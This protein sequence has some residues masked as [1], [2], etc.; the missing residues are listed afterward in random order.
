[1]GTALGQ[2]DLELALFVTVNVLAALWLLYI[3][4]YNSKLTGFIVTR[5]INK[6][7]LR[8]NGHLK[9]G[10]DTGLICKKNTGANM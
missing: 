3:F 6:F 5:A 10:T 8:G 4:F 7:V 9:I 2:V 1:M